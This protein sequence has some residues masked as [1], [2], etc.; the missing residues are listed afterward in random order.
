MP[1]VANAE[2][3]QAD[4]HTDTMAKTAKDPYSEAVADT[5]VDTT[6]YTNPQ[7]HAEVTA[8]DDHPR[9]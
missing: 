1:Y 4:S 5:A 7:A 8:S 9:P 3:A 6:T 2:V